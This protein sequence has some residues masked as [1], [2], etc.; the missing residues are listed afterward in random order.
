MSSA[1]AQRFAARY[2]L[3]DLLKAP[4]ADEQCPSAPVP[5][6]HPGPPSS[7][8]E[9]IVCNDLT[10][11]CPRCPTCPSELA[12]VGDEQGLFDVLPE[13]AIE[14]LS[15]S[16]DPWAQGIARL[17]AMASLNGFS[18]RQW[19]WVQY[20]CAA[21]Q[22]SHGTELRRLGWT[23]EDAFGIHP[24]VG[25]HAVHCY[26]LGVLLRDSRVV[27]LTDKF[28]RIRLRSGGHQTFTRVPNIL[29]VPIWLA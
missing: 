24:E 11:G 12:Q 4:V 23:T 22:A 28:A 21:L 1:A 5:H 8:P 25:G 10:G 19:A 16:I 20:G 26:G 17:Q 15:V 13:L 18:Q 27:E 3:D 9:D 6:Q 29:A 2:G 14:N 7:T